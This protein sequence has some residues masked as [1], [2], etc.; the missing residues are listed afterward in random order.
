MNK[1][2]TFK[3]WFLVDKAWKQNFQIKS[4]FPQSETWMCSNFLPSITF[5]S[6]FGNRKQL[7]KSRSKIK[8]FWTGEDVTINHIAYKDNAVELCD[9]SIGFT[10][11]EIIDARNYVRYPLW[12]LYYFGKNKDLNEIQVEVDAFNKRWLELAHKKIKFC[13]LVASHDNY[14]TRKQLFELLNP[15]EPVKC[16]GKIFHNDDTMVTEFADDKVKYLE[17][18]MF[19]ICPE[20]VSAPGYT[21]EK[22]FQSFDSGCIPI[23]YGSEGVVEPEVVDNSK[24]IF[25]DGKNGGEVLSKVKM[26]YEN[27][28][29]YMEFMST[30]PLKDTAAQWIYNK[31]IQL[32]KKLEE[33][34]K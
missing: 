22:V 29:K 9:L 20:N 3:N 10:P 24:I 32:Q 19:N 15:Y 12:L 4:F 7:E 11:E 5:F 25:F 31:N 2:F 23:Y 28:D 8:I 30:P 17:Q 1:R 6:V 14:G 26:F 34:I 18:F 27:K 33:I 21:T 16:A 13:S